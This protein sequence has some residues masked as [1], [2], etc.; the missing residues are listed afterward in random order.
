M[1]RINLFTVLMLFIANLIYS[2]ETT[3]TSETTSI[4]KGLNMYVFPSQDQDQTTMDAD[5]I[6]CYKWAMK[7]TGYDPINPP[8]IKAEQVDTSPEGHAVVGAAKGAAAGAAIGAIAGDAG[9]GAAI[10]AVAGGLAGRRAK[11]AGDRQKQQ[12]NNQDAEAKK[13]AMLD[14]FK[15]A[16]SVCME[17]KGYNIK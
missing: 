9:K 12:Q 13:K 8:Q 16:F 15:K 6:A 1:I 17:S 2:Q 4:A 7:Q 11:K 5:E 10:G 3:T 14:D